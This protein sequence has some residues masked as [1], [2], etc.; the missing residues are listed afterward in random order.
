ML[1]LLLPLSALAQN[2]CQASFLPSVINAS[3]YQL[4]DQSS[5][6][7]GVAQYLWNFGDGSFSN[8]Q[9]PS[10]A[11]A[12]PGWYAV[13]LTITSNN[14]CTSTYCDSVQ[15]QQGCGTCHAQYAAT[16]NGAIVTFTDLSTASNTIA[17]WYWD[18]DD[19]S[20]SYGQNQTHA[21]TTTGFYEICLTIT[22]VDS[23]VDTYC[24]SIYV[25]CGTQQ[26]SCDADF[27]YVDSSGT[28][29][30]N[31][32]STASSAIIGWYWDFND[33]NVSSAQNPA[34]TYQN[35]GTYYPCLTIFTADSCYDTH[36]D[37]VVVNNCV[38]G[39]ASFT[40]TINGNTVSFQ[41]T[42]QGCYASSGWVF[43]GAGSSSQTNPTITFPGPGSYSACLCIY[44]AA[45]NIC[46]IVCQTV[47][48]AGCNANANFTYTQ[49][50][51]TFNF[52]NVPSPGSFLWWNFGDGNTSTTSNP[53]HTY[54]TPGTYNVC[55]IVQ[56]S[57]FY[58]VDTICQTVTVTGCAANASISYTVNGNTAAFQSG[59]TGLNNPTYY[60]YFQSGTPSSSGAANPTT[61]F[62]GP[63]TYYACLT[64]ADSSNWQC[65][66]STCVQVVI[67][68]CNANANFTYTQNG[69]TFNFSNTVVP[70]STLWWSF[71]DGANAFVNNPT[72]T[73]ASPG[74]YTVCLLVQ[75]SATLC[76]D[77]VC[78]SVT[79]AGCNATANITYTVSGNTVSFQSGP[80]GINN[81]NYYWYFQS[82][83][84]G[85][86]SAAN[87]TTT[88]PGPGT[89]YACLTVSDSSWQCY[90]STCVQVVI[91]GCAATANISYNVIGNTVSFQSGP[92][93]INNPNYYWYFQSGSPGSS[94][95]ANP[96]TTFPGP[97][98][99]FACLTVSDSGWQ[100][101]DSTCVQIV[102]SGCNANANFSYTQSG[103]TVSF[104]NTS[105][106]VTSQWWSFG[107]GNV[108][109]SY[110]PTHTYATSGTYN[111]CL[112]VQDTIS[113]CL[114]TICQPVTI[115]GCNATA[116]I[117]YTVS[118]N[119]VSFQS[120]PTGINNPNYYW[121]FQS[122]TPGSSSA[123]NP[124]TTFP[125]PG[126]YYACLTVS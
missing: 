19:G 32:Q 38:C 114:D 117:T 125:G 99:Y 6:A 59:S 27:S 111:V 54:T 73:Y 9:S 41:N 65:Y 60:W 58:C 44:D 64:V 3:S 43:S 112:I 90:D 14:G 48:I 61:T 92:T 118:G 97:G 23:C 51:S 35:S 66:D 82:G 74:T 106:G 37:T 63:G 126:T 95:A 4:T 80:T 94:S 72:H 40:Y 113:W 55:L 8:L 78:Q 7:S 115:S 119:T 77:T 120:G 98:T 100:C 36:C 107:D 33:G 93:G 16:A 50:G 22:T 116:N 12:N 68:G 88:F 109:S 5:A 83:S 46:D 31:D 1:C 34:H 69:S 20:F 30:F 11:W 105:S 25:Q 49:N 84:P 52:S 85:S 39:P 24:D 57:A 29:F 67:P 87:P 124:T 28:V 18:F 76:T 81:P 122:G 2:T 79:V 47:V 123:A 21:Y 121:Y 102:I 101:Y 42:S 53:T 45:G 10:H 86:S 89:Y 26:P 103:N 15:V 91:P 104:N 56:D 71:G 110:S 75:D 70:G 13:C 62:P 96:T 17:S 108:S